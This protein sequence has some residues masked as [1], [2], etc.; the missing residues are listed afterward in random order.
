MTD[1]HIEAG[2]I[3]RSVVIT[4]DNNRATL[5]FGDAFTL[6]LERRQCPPPARRQQNRDALPDLLSLLAPDADK[7]PLVG[8]EAALQELQAWLD[9]DIDVSVKALIARA[10]SGKTRLAVEGVAELI[11]GR[12]AEARV[13]L[14][15]AVSR[16][17]EI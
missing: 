8:R 15:L 9:G 13:S 16:R 17:L 6:P 3:E 7:I 2:N 12:R 10:G 11:L 1:R 14:G 4:G 5:V